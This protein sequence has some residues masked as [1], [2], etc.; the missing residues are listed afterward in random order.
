MTIGEK[1]SR[2]D[3]VRL[4]NWDKDESSTVYGYTIKHGTCPIFVTYNKK[5]DI[6]ETTQYQDGFLSNK[7][8]HW[9]SRSNKHFETKEVAEIM[10]S[11]DTG[12]TLHLF[13]KKEDGEGYDFYY[14]G[15]VH[16]IENSALETTMPDGETPV[17]TMN[18]E[19]INEVPS[20]LYDYLTKK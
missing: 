13:I 2:K 10:Q 15:P 4:L 3:A 14:L 18:F 8:F 12:L 9:Y 6:T 16:Y 11:N 1:Y 5:D 7:V 19:L 17:V 20:P